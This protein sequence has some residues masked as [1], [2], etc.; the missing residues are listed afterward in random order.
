M[1][2]TSSPISSGSFASPCAIFLA[3]VDLAPPHAAHP[4]V[5]HGGAR[6]RLHGDVLRVAAPVLEEVAAGPEVAPARAFVREGKLAGDGLQGG[7]VLVRGRQRD[8]AEQPVGVGMLR[9]REQRVDGPF[10]DHL[11]RVHDEHPVADLQ[12]EAEVV[13][14]VDLGGAV[15][16]ADVGDELGDAGLDGDVERGGRLVE[17]QERRVREQRH[18]DDHALLLPAGDLV[19]VRRHDPVGVRE[20]HVGEHL[21]RAVVGLGVRDAIVGHRDFLELGSPA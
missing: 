15:L 6:H 20:A 18:R 3:V 16:A 1:A 9:P 10:L 14:D 2:R 11:A 21:H 4:V 13:R 7:R 8:A 19:R 17:E 12:D 5:A